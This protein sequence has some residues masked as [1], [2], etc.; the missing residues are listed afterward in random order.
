MLGKHTLAP[1]EKTE[2]KV[3]YDTEMRPGPFEKHVTLTTNIPGYEEIEIFVIKGVVEEAPGAK[4]AVVPRRVL[5]EGAERGTGK[6][7]AFSITNEGSLP[8][9]ITGIRSDDGKTVYF[10]GSKSGNITIEPGQTK[11]RE[12]QLPGIAGDKEKGEYMLIRSNARNAGNSGFH[13]LIQYPAIDMK[14]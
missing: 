12:L 11:I 10:D 4:I 7:Q 1:N 13:I 9:V 3:S 5:L 14:K 6:K 2:I 8:L